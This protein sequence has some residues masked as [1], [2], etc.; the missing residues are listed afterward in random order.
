VSRIG[1]MPINIPDGVEVKINKGNISVRGKLGELSQEFDTSSIQLKVKDSVLTV[2]PVSDSKENRAKYGLYRSLIN[3]MVQGV[4]IGFS[5]TLKI[6]GVGYRVSKKGDS[7]DILA[8][9][10]APVTVDPPEGISFDV[11]DN[12]TIVVKGVKKQV[13][14]ETAAKIRAIRK[15]E[16]YKGK[17]IKYEDEIIRRKVGKAAITA[18]GSVGAAKTGG[19]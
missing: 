6:V 16:P 8:G 7:L 9:F 12:T 5:K 13:V 1:K 19:S 17:G 15:P 11:P 14:G 3:N 4:S 18:A 2:T 10:S